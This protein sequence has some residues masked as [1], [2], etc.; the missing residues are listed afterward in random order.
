MT[1]KVTQPWSIAGDIVDASPCL[2]HGPHGTG[3]TP[4]P[5]DMSQR[6]L[7]QSLAT[8]RLGGSLRSWQKLILLCWPPNTSVM[9]PDE[10]RVSNMLSTDCLLLISV[11][12]KTATLQLGESFAMIC[13]IS[14][15]FSDR[16]ATRMTWFAPAWVND[17]AIALPKSVP[18]PVTITILPVA[19]FFR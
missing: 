16:R 2:F 9:S 8:M 3:C 6:S 7:L 17:W 5:K 4:G 13:L 19:A 15:S 1:C 11:L 12:P 10:T 18:D 14:S